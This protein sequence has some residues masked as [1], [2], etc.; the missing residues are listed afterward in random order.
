MSL[1]GRKFAA[2][3]S[4]HCYARLMTNS[5]EVGI[6]DSNQ[7]SLI[8]LMLSPAELHNNIFSEKVAEEIR[9]WALS[10]WLIRWGK[11]ICMALLLLI[12]IGST[13]AVFRQRCFFKYLFERKKS[14]TDSFCNNVENTRRFGLMV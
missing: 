10:F 7:N 12:S 13:T 6:R 14:L 2:I 11:T 8:M 3:S 1:T 4:E 9:F 5:E